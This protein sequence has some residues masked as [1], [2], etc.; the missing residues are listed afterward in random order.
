MSVHYTRFDSETQESPCFAVKIAGKA[1]AISIGLAPWQVETYN[2]GMKKIM[3]AVLILVCLPA[4]V[5]AE[6]E[7]IYWTAD[8]YKRAAR[9]DIGEALFMGEAVEEIDGFARI[10][11]V[12]FTL[13]PV[14]DSGG[15][16]R[17]SHTT[18]G[19]GT[20]KLE[21]A[22]A[23]DDGW[24]AAGSSSSS[25]FDTVWHEGWYD[26]KEAKTDGWIVRLDNEGET[27]WMRM[28]GGTDWDSFHAICPASDGGW[29]VVGNTYSSDGDV[30]GWHD[31]GEMF[32]QPDGWM[33]HI[34][35]AGDIVW[36][37]TLGGSGY[38]ELLGVKQVPGG[39]LAVGTTDSMDGDVT[40]LNGDRDGWVVLVDEA[41]NLVEQYC[42]GG[43]R[44]DS[45]V[46][47]AEGDEGFLAVGTSWSFAKDAENREE[48]SWAVLLN[49]QGEAQ[50]MQRFGVEQF[51]YPEYA[52]W[53]T[54]YWAVAGYTMEGEKQK[55]WLIGIPEGAG[56]WKLIRRID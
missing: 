46:T 30:V 49:D 23:T 25:D 21:Q 22:V 10:V 32:M 4:C 42:Y 48:T 8:T 51:E 44:E 37:C 43:D 18:V 41:G 9:N 13:L 20:N 26:G 3:I 50:W 35:D 40:G 39:Y 47:L 1:L 16:V 36:Q 6:T 54:D 55:P 45:F 7:T 33:L 38:D 11:G 53:V 15:E 14:K 29:I 5:L 56:E 2:S 52:G 12:S 19:N 31:S 27:V 24:I 28:Y 34:D 17:W